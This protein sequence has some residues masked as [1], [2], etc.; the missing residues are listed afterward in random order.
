MTIKGLVDGNIASYVGPEYM[1]IL[2]T[3][4]MTPNSIINTLLDVR[5]GLKWEPTNPTYVSIFRSG[6]I[7]TET[8]TWFSAM[9]GVVSELNAELSR[10]SER[11][12]GMSLEMNRLSEMVARLADVSIFAVSLW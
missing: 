5:E 10:Y 8:R 6:R 4:P 9:V 12:R 3:K 2:R 7:S 11:F 1:N